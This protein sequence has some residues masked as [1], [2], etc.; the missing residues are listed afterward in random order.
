MSGFKH[1]AY[2]AE[3]SR[4]KVLCTLEHVLCLQKLV[5]YLLQNPEGCSAYTCIRVSSSDCRPRNRRR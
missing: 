1:G 5:K 4:D 2:S 3:H